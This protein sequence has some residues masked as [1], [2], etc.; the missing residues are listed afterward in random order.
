MTLKH[1][2]WEEY[3]FTAEPPLPYD[4]TFRV[5]SLQDETHFENIS[6]HKLL[7]ASVSEVFQTQFFGSLADEQKV[8][9]I[10]DTTLHA[11]KECLQRKR[12]L[13]LNYFRLILIVSR[14]IYE[15][16]E[17]YGENRK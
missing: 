11:F 16:N 17:K 14:T 12:F 8:I 9:E 4:V 15:K 7:L 5:F 1:V 3:I 10:K 2:N 13:T 6:A